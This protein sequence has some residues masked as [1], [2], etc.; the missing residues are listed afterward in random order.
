[1][2]PGS[3][4]FVAAEATFFCG[5]EA[6]AVINN[7]NALSGGSNGQKQDILNFLRSL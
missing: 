5:S 6:N 2:E 4:Q 7:F 1:M 3:N